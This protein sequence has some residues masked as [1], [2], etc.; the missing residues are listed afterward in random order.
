[1]SEL[2]IYTALVKYVCTGAVFLTQFMIIIASIL[3]TS[4]TF[5]PDGPTSEN[6]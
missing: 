4:V 6:H 3:F 2:T 1:L 5:A